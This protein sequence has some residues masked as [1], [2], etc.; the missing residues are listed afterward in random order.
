M[1]VH[2][3]MDDSRCHPNRPYDPHWI[4]DVSDEWVVENSDDIERVYCRMYQEVWL[5][6]GKEYA[7]QLRV[8]N[9]A[10]AL[11]AMLSQPLATSH[12]E[13]GEGSGGCGGGGGGGDG[14]GG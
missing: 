5:T 9:F 13:G 10:F 3:T 14:S 4:N 2:I 6:L 12:I 8:G 11:K 7:Q 1:S